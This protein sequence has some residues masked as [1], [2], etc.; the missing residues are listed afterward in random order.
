MKI[1]LSIAAG[2]AWGFLGAMINY[3]IMKKAIAANDAG[4][5]TAVTVVRTAI[6]ALFLGMVFCVRNVS[7]FNFAFAITATAAALS[8]TTIVM[9]FKLAKPEKASDENKE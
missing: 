1:V 2:L 3:Y 5:V 4:K 7:A 8:I 6:D 9:T